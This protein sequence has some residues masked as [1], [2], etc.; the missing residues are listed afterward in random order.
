ME[1][2]R[3]I[4]SCLEHADMAI[5]LV[6]VDN[7][8]NDGTREMLEKWRFPE[9][10]IPKL[11]FSNN[12]LGVAGGRNKAFEMCSSDII[13]FIDDDAYI[14]KDSC[15]IRTAVEYMNQNREVF[16]LATEIYDTKNQS[17]SMNG[18]IDEKYDDRHRYAFSYIG[19][20]HF[21]RKSLVHSKVLY[22][23]TLM[24]GSEEFYAT[25]IAGGYNNATVYFNEFKVIHDPSNKMRLSTSEI[26]Y[27]VAV[28]KCV[29]KKLLFPKPL[30]EICTVLFIMRLMHE[31]GLR[32]GKVKEG[33]CDLNKRLKDNRE[34]YYHI[35]YSGWKGLAKR[36]GYLR[37]I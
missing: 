9:Y 36:F 6:I 23:P 29:V 14:K 11:Y 3:T 13:Y 20:S 30:S 28:N 25:M 37:V 32:K 12:N 15:S 18:V 24:Y 33:I 22:P 16:A 31:Y 35:S 27:N 10:C 2:K 19:A 1:L 26:Y 17:Y 34:C 7:G 5:E 8:S 21:I 4:E